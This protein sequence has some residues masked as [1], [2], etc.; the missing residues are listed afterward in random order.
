MAIWFLWCQEILKYLT[1]TGK[2]HFDVPFYW[3][4]L[5]VALTGL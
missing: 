4:I 5:N 1:L 2:A 3:Q